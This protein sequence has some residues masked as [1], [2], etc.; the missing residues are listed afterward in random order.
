MNTPEGLNYVH[1]RTLLAEMRKCRLGLVQA[2]E[3]LRFVYQSVIE[4]LDSDWEAEN[5]V[6][7]IIQKNVVLFFERLWLIIFFNIFIFK[8]LLFQLSQ[9]LF[10]FIKFFYFLYCNIIK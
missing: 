9:T 4:A 3:Q 5:E 7:I 2:P 10:F 8:L 6:N 1:I